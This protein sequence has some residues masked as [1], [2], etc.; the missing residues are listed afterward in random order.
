M[1]GPVPITAIT[2]QIVRTPIVQ[3]V[4][5]SFGTM[6]DRPEVILRLT[7]DRGNTGLGEVWCNFPSMAAEHR[8]RIAEEL[9]GPVL[10]EAREIE[11]DGAFEWLMA[12]FHILCIQSGE[13]GP[14]AQVASA[15]D[16]ALHDL[17]ARRARVPLYAWLSDGAR[18]QIPCYASGIGPEAP[19]RTID[20]ARR[21]GHVRFKIKLG[22]GQN[23]DVATL[24]AARQAAGDDD[25]M[26]DANQRW[27]PEDA[28]DILPRLL[29]YDL[30]WI[31]E[32]ISADQSLDCWRGLMSLGS[33][34]LAAGENLN[35]R[36]AFTAMAELIAFVQPDVAKWGGVSTIMELT[37]DD[38]GPTY[39]PHFLGGGVGLLTSAHML[40]A[41][42][43]AGILECDINP[44]ARR[45][46][47]L[48]EILRFCDGMAILSDAPGIGPVNTLE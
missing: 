45:K 35:S 37:A 19:A 26:A 14:F 1:T 33:P 3:P 47:M 2:A 11:P 15:V 24:K 31:E 38:T 10:L 42:G 27:S 8:A 13:W 44:N 23:T 20:T 21:A 34:P 22:F 12:R 39:C 5:T 25:L 43:G 36:A 16:A 17:A 7:D 41:Q 46:T 6:T 9:F 48:R 29:P 28:R 18:N 40:A 30:R 32:P 4:R